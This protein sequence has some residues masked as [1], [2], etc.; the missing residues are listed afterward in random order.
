MSVDNQ[1]EVIAIIET[2]LSLEAGELKANSI[3]EDIDNWDSL[4]QLSILVSLDKHFNGQIKD[5]PQ[6]GTVDSV[7]KILNILKENSII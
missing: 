4:G 7:E 5:L 1:S 6:M 3:S 2:A